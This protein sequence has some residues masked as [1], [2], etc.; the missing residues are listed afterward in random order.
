M[1]MQREIAL[2]A[3]KDDVTPERLAQRHL[4]KQEQYKTLKR[5]KI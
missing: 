3:N 1:K 2:L 5:N 4:C